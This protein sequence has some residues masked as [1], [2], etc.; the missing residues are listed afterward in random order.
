MI[1]VKDLIKD[2]KKLDS[3]AEINITVMDLDGDTVQSYYDF[4]IADYTDTDNNYI[5]IMLSEEDNVTL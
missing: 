3:G 2:L 4:A 1:L 5:E